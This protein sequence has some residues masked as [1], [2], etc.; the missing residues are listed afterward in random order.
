MFLAQIIS[1]PSDGS[2]QYVK[3]RDDNEL[4]SCD[5]SLRRVSV[6]SILGSERNPTLHIQHYQQGM[7]QIFHKAIFKT[8]YNKCLDSLCIYEA[9]F[10]DPEICITEI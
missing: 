10:F 6:L 7:N 9:G 3:Q 8:F 2:S 4:H 1:S 5:F